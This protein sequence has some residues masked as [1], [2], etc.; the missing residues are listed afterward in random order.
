MTAEYALKSVLGVGT[1]AQVHSAGLIEAPHE[2]VSFVKE[3]LL[4]K[5]IDVSDHQPRKINRAML[6]QANLAV[7]MDHPH[8]REISTIYGRHIPL[9]SEVA[10]AKVSA[11]PD[12][13]EVVADWRNNEAAAREYGWSVMDIIFDGMPGLLRHLQDTFGGIEE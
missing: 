7:A 9:F 10:Y 13:N 1:E 8:Q 3:Y 5:G 11:L 4:G 6:E 12:V 2:I